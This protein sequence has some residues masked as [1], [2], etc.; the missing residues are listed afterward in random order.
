MK[1]KYIN[2]TLCDQPGIRFSLYTS[3]YYLSLYSEKV[4]IKEKTAKDS[5]S[6]PGYVIAVFIKICW[7]KFYK[8]PVDIRLRKEKLS[9]FG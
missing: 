7:N 5:F 2:K 3:I 6:T 8:F 9:F 4:S 1:V